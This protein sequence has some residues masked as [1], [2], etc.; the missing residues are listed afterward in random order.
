MRVI[1]SDPISRRRIAE[2]RGSGILN[3]LI[4]KLPF[5]VHI[6][7]YSYCGPGTKLAKRLARGDR[8]V[9]PLD[10]ACRV[11]DIA[12]SQSNDLSERHKADKILAEKA[13]E[14][15]K[16]RESGL[17]EKAAALA[18]TGA[19]KTKLLTGMGHRRRKS[20]RSTVGQGISYQTAMRVARRRRRRG[21]FKRGTTQRVIPI[22]KKSG[23]F[24]PLLLGG[25]GALGS[26]IGGGSSVYQAIKKAKQAQKNL[27]EAKRHNEKMEAIAIG[28]TADGK[29]LYM[30]PYKSGL[31][32]YVGHPKNY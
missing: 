21:G 18:I 4:N 26:L 31:G 20:R 30:G 27:E 13:I 11:H 7:G 28:K 8:G 32:L 2:R 17:G 12:Y 6:P 19:M 5:E 10:A 22:P 16:S 1:Y 29:G 15:L 24:L 25:L 3:K 9:N 14:R 23:G